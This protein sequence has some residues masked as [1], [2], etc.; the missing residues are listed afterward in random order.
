MRAQ[1]LGYVS[2]SKSMTVE[3]TEQ[4]R[5]RLFALIIQFSGTEVCKIRSFAH[6]I[7]PLVA[8]CP[9]IKYEKLYCKIL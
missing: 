6:L 5:A 9:G 8:A 3:L 7:G 4:K 2:N 1:Y